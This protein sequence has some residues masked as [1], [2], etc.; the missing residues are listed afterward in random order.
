MD[1]FAIMDNLE[2]LNVATHVHWCSFPNGK[3]IY[4]YILLF[5]PCY[6]DTE[7]DVQGLLENKEYKFR[8]SAVNENGTGEPLEAENSIIAK[9]PFG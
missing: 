8:V 2:K 4:L 6:Q 9:L 7:I 5:L 1:I 3:T